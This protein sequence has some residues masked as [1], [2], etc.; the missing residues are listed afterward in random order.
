LKRLGLAELLR[1]AQG[2]D[3]QDQKAENPEKTGCRKRIEE[4]SLLLSNGGALAL[5]RGTA[6]RE[7]RNPDLPLQGRRV[8]RGRR[9]PDVPHRDSDP[10][11][12]DLTIIA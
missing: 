9:A 2:I 5:P 12:V 7:L 8:R 3:I 6:V 11:D 1:G 10:A 4:K